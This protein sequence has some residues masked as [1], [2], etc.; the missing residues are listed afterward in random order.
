M[1]GK[2]ISLYTLPTPAAA[3][4]APVFISKGELLMDRFSE[5]LSVRIT[6]HSLDE[7]QIH[8]VKLVCNYLMKL[9]LQSMRV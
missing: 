4:E 9:A 2:Y 3:A 1:A 5:T 8:A 7:R 6:M